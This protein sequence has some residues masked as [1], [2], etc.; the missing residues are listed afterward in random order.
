MNQSA[1][2]EANN[3]SPLGNDVW[4]RCSRW[5]CGHRKNGNHQG[6]VI[7]SSVRE[8]RFRFLHALYDRDET[9]S[10]EQSLLLTDGLPNWR[11]TRYEWIQCVLYCAP[12]IETYPQSMGNCV[13]LRIRLQVFPICPQLKT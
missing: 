7:G 13:L 8:V 4:L 6:A 3:I 9:E 5:A 11:P 1:C 2:L 12:F 10:F